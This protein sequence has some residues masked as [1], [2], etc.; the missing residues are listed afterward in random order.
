MG[1]TA[2]EIL[3]LDFDPCFPHSAHTLSCRTPSDTRHPIGDEFYFV[4]KSLSFRKSLIGEKLRPNCINLN[5]L[6]VMLNG[7]GYCVRKE[8]PPRFTYPFPRPPNLSLVI[9]SGSPNSNGSLDLDH[10]IRRVPVGQILRNF[11]SFGIQYWLKFYDFKF[12]MVLKGLA[13]KC[14]SL[15]H[16]LTVLINS[17]LASCKSDP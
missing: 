14:N 6:A 10:S 16:F 2:L 5:I 15:R 11:A 7:E 17:N 9:L 4:L 1:L 13:L 8:C 3:R 12:E